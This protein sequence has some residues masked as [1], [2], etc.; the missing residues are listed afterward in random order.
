[1]MIPLSLKLNQDWAWSSDW[2]GEEVGL[3]CESVGYY[4]S[5]IEFFT[6]SN[7]EDEATLN[8]YVD[9]ETGEI[10]QMWVSKEED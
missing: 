4:T 2:M 9:N 10:L 7:D 6:D 3:N 1:M 8:V 5:P